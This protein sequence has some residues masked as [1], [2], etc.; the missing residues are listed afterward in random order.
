ME[1]GKKKKE[2]EKHTYIVI[3]K[4]S[5]KFNFVRKKGF[6]HRSHGIVG[7]VKGR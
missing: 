7:A 6:L 2:G 5:L 1:R 4:E 3:E